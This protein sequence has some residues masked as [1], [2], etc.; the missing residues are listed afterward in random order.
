[1]RFFN[2]VIWDGEFIKLS[3]GVSVYGSST[4][5]CDDYEGVY[6]PS[7]VLKCIYQWVILSVF[8]F[9]GLFGKPIMAICEFHELEVCA[10]EGGIGIWLWGFLLCIGWQLLVLVDIDM[11]GVCKCI[12]VP[13]LNLL[14]QACCY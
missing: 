6:F 9:K 13:N 11:V 8:L 7:I 5:G 10:R 1:M 14:S 3:Y 12:Q 4:F 2:G